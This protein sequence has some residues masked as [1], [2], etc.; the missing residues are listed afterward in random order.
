MLEL[1]L[2]NYVLLRMDLCCIGGTLSVLWRDS[3]FKK[4]IFITIMI[5]K[6]N[7]KVK[8]KMRQ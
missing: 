3:I 8:Y 2:V 1:L 5:I 7:R 4:L 6:K